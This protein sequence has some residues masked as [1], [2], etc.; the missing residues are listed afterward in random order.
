MRAACTALIIGLSLAGAAARAADAPRPASFVPLPAP[1][2]GLEPLIAALS[3]RPPTPGGV[4]VPAAFNRVAVPLD[5]DGHYAVQAKVNNQVWV[6]FIVDTGATVV[7]LGRNHAEAL[8][9]YPRDRSA[10]TIQARTANGTIRLA[11]VMLDQIRIERL[12][13]SSVPAVVSEG[14]QERALLGMNFLRQLSRFEVR[15]GELVME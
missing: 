13:V 9:I 1:A 6:D 4:A 5:R 14:D 7:L 10:F 2:A 8:R 3:P 12:T 11:P 15:N